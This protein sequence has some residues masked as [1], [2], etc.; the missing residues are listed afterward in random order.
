[1]KAKAGVINLKSIKE[2]LKN[3][4]ENLRDINKNTI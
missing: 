1:M 3:I 2:N 4:K